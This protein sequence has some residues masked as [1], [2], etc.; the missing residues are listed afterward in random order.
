MLKQL[1]DTINYI[2]EHLLDE[3]VIDEAMKRVSVSDLIKKWTILR[4][5]NAPL[6]LN[7][8]CPALGGALHV[9]W[10]QKKCVI[11]NMN[12]YGSLKVSVCAARLS[13]DSMFSSAEDFTS[14]TD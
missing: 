3:K 13:A 11:K 1:N 7:F 2:E 5:K 14:I 4:K 8:I 6:K 9:Y 10:H 12:L